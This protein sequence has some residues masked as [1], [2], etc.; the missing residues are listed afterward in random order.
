MLHRKPCCLTSDLSFLFCWQIMQL[1]L[2]MH[3]LEALVSIN[4]FMSDSADLCVHFP[5][6]I[7]LA[8]SS[9]Y[10]MSYVNDIGH[11][12]NYI[13]STMVSNDYKKVAFATFYVN[14]PFV[15]RNCPYQ[16]NSK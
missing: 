16:E 12:K 7:S 9:D 1:P 13:Y 15:V 6:F 5:H 3:I 8:H 11:I 4:A 14:K 10:H 2:L